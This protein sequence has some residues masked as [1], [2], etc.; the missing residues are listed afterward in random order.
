MTTTTRSRCLAKALSDLRPVDPQHR[1]HL[2]TY[3]DD[4]H[5]GLHVCECGVSFVSDQP[6]QNRPEESAAGTGPVYLLS[7][8]AHNAWWRPN[9]PGYPAH[10]DQAGRFT[11]AEAIRYVFASAQSGIRDKVT[12]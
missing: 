11:E 10:N 12:V 4:R 7:S 1:W 6:E 9:G 2:C 8:Q 3:D 5:V